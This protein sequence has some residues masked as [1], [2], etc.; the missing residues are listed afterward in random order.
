MKWDPTETSPGAFNYTLGDQLV[1]FAQSHGMHVKGHTL[2]W[3]QSLPAWVSALPD[4]A[5]VDAA[6]QNHI[7]NVVT[8]WKGKVEVWDV[9][10]EAI[11]DGSS[12][13]RSSVFFDKLGAGYVEKAFR[14]ARA[15][16]PDVLLFYNDYG[17][18][19]PGMK[20]DGIYDLVKG[21]VDAGAPIDGVGFQMHIAAGDV[22]GPVFA[23]TMKRFTALGLRVNVSEMDV[24]VHGVTGGM[25]A[26]LDAGAASFHDI[27]AA[28]VAEPMCQ[29]VTVWGLTDDTSWINGSGNTFYPKPDYPLL[30]DASYTPKP[31][32][33]GVVDA[34]MGR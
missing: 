5:S 8:H 25:P 4:A 9:V 12:A 16:D 32:Y 34:L 31:A 6:L 17:G 10:N 2:V 1:A 22:S 23:A 7:Q 29:A 3:Y 14:Y 24:R 33:A 11:A 27:T 13:L 15:A 30:F 28:C 19:L 26:Q 21:L 18:E 20:Q